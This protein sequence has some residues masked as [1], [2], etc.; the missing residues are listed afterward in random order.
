M[1]YSEEKELDQVSSVS[2]EKIRAFVLEQAKSLRPEKLDAESVPFWKGLKEQGTELWLDTGDSDAASDIWVG[3]FTALTTNNTLLNTEIQ[4]G[5]YDDLIPEANELLADIEIGLRVIEIAFILNAVHA[6]RLVARFDTR[7]SV[8]LHTAVAHDLKATIAYAKRFHDISPDRFIVKI[9][10]TPTGLIATRQVRDLGIPVNF[11][12]GFSARQN[13]FATALSR[14]SYVNVFLGR[15]NAYVA[16]NELGTGDMVGEKATI[17]SQRVIRDIA[18]TNPEP[19]KHIAASMRTAQQ[20][21]DL[22]GVDV[23]TMPIKVADT[24][25]KNLNSSWTDRTQEDYPVE[26][27]SSAI[28]K[29][30]SILWD[31]SPEENQAAQALGKFLP[32]SG[33]MLVEQ[34]HAR[35]IKSLFPYLSPQD[36]KTLADEGKI[37]KH[38]TWSK[39][40]EAGE[41]AID[42]IAN[43]AA[44]ESFKKDQVA[45]DDRIRGLI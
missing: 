30:V 28:A 37:P 18:K 29:Q 33:N 36:Y 10:L 4:K 6:L 1:I 26:F 42:T 16:D 19:T 20:V 13:L 14:P 45:L 17:A 7:V 12:L 40:I 23:Y 9:P 39:R 5:I 21:A 32:T 8:E 27:K 31:I 11:T 25:R 41:I 38:A 24:A 3:D 43:L 22:A 34:L 35:G 2:A 44:L 15:L